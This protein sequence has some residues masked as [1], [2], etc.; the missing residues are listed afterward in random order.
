MR[1]CQ[2]RGYVYELFIGY[3]LEKIGFVR[4][5][6]GANNGL[7]DCVNNQGEIEGRGEYHQIDFAG[8]YST[9]IPFTYPMRI[10]VECKFYTKKITK[11]QIREFIGVYKDINENYI[12]PSEIKESNTYSITDNGFVRYLDIPV[13]FSANGFDS[14]A[15][16]LAWAHGIN[17][18]SHVLKPLNS[19]K[20]FIE[21]FTTQIYTTLKQL[22]EKGDKDLFKSC[23]DVF[24]KPNGKNKKGFSVNFKKLKNILQDNNK[25]YKFIDCIDN[26]SSE[27]CDSY[28]NFN[29]KEF[30]EMTWLLVT[31]DKGHIINLLS[32][33][34]FPYELYDNGSHSAKAKIY[35]NVDRDNNY[36][37]IEFDDDN[38]KRKF[39]FNV[40][41]RLLSK[42]FNTLSNKVKKE[43]KNKYVSKMS[44]IDPRGNKNKILYIDV[45]FDDLVLKKVGEKR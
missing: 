38:K 44:F 6:H 24:E 16:N 8:I 42:S 29:F 15:E 31:T 12:V 26:N 18:V 34:E 33:D 5:E 28:M 25:L 40:P 35:Y 45:T 14:H 7:L 19:L 11:K 20:K 39:S 9:Q 23:D 36:F 41:V 3:M 22:N 32:K 1:E 4:C 2:I 13:F 21:C 37:Y 43:K 17:L 27:N 30:E 10:I